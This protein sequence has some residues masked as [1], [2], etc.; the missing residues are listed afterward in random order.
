MAEFRAQESAEA[1]PLYVDPI[2]PIFLDA[3]TK[4]AADAIS[5]GFPAAGMN[6]RIRTR[7]LDDRLDEQL[8]RGC[9]QVVILG[10]GLDTRAVRKQSPGVVYFEIDDAS[11]LNFK[12]S[13]LAESGIDTPINFIPG[14]YVVDGVL[15]LLEA[16]GFKRELPAF[17]IW[18]GNT[19]YLTR[20]AVMKVLAE[21]RER[22]RA[23][24][25]SFDYMS[26]EVIAYATG[27]RGT[28]EFVERFAA[29]GAPWH[30]GL[31]DLDALAEE[32]DL[33]VVDAVTVAD[34]HRAYRPGR[35]LAS[36]IYQHYS[37][38]TLKHGSSDQQGIG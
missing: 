13:R 26:E 3:R 9:R 19:M 2:V 18:E 36:I 37:L 7:Y 14:D 11:T 20:D 34:L 31:N 1:N 21:L 25:L 17:F 35:P 30:F 27:D 15:P 24:S 38:C 4:Q 16:N 23:F 8:A 10:A 33:T 6:V 5:S 29:M 22:V 28:T 32:P 12:Q